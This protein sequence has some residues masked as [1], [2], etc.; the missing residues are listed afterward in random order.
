MVMKKGKK[1]GGKSAADHMQPARFGGL[2]H[3]R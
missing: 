1:G 2:F 3:L